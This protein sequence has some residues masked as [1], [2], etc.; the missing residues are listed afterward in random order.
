M[1]YSDDDVAEMQ[2][3]CEDWLERE[4]TLT[5]SLFRLQLQVPQAREMMTHGVCRRL[6]DLKHGLRRVFETLPPQEA[7]PAREAIWD[8][9]LP[10]S[11]RHQHFRRHGQLGLALVSGSRR[12]RP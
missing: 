2:D 5:S 3:R 1:A 6:S 12:A 8:A 7:E 9:S 10:P 11:L 4:G